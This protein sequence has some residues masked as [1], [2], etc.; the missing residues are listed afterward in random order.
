MEAYLT[1]RP[2]H[3]FK[4]DVFFNFQARRMLE[5]KNVQFHMARIRPPNYGTITAVIMHLIKH[6]THTPIAFAPYLRDA[7]R[8]LRATEIPVRFGMLFLHDLDLEGG[9]I[10][11]IDE[12]DSEECKRDMEAARTSKIRRA[13]ASEAGPSAQFPIGNAPT[14]EEVKTVL[15]LNPALFLRAWVFSPEWHVNDQA[16]DLFVQFT[17]DY[18]LTL[19]SR[20][21][22]AGV[23]R[24]PEKSLGDAMGFWT[25]S[26]LMQAITHV[27]FIPSNHGVHA[28]ALQGQTHKS[29]TSWKDVFFPPMDKPGGLSSAWKELWEQGY[30]HEYHELMEELSDDEIENLNTHLGD[31]FG[32]LQ[33][34]PDAVSH[35]ANAPGKLWSL[36][37]NQIR[38]WVNPIFYKLER[39]SAAKR[40]S[41]KTTSRVKANRDTIVARLLEARGGDDSELNGSRVRKQRRAVN[42]RKKWMM[43]E[44]SGKG[45]NKRI[46]P[47]Q[48]RDNLQ[49]ASSMQKKIASDNSDDNSFENLPVDGDSDVSSWEA[50][51]QREDEE[52]ELN[53]SDSDGNRDEQEDYNM[54]VDE[55]Y[56]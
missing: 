6:V 2:L 30:I 5:L 41:R 11:E 52:E 54:D 43:A 46:P 25:V 4:S 40:K 35:G 21:L 13:V 45:K 34:L 37:D 36:A 26:S 27:R 42:K 55:D 51:E 48:R 3:C 18:S 16:S 10:R 47:H 53:G 20:S 17:I 56:E 44:K 38:I 7:L 14:W 19:D 8:D 33:C 32:R 15:L 28:G 49:A 1:G 23:P 12:E 22:L 31:I 9:T 24:L 39:I 50:G 29:F